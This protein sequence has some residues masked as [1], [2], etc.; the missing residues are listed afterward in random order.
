[1]QTARNQGRLK[2]LLFL[3][4]WPTYAYFYQ[5][6]S[7]NEAARLDQARALVE[8]GSLWVDTYAYNSADLI[9]YERDG[10]RHFYSGK[11]PGTTLLAAIPLKVWSTTL[12][13]LGLP[14]AV[15]WHWV[16]Y[17]TTISTVS[18]LSALAA[19]AVFEA[20]L[21]ITASVPFA[22]LGVIAVW[23]GSISFPFS[24]LMFG[25]QIAASLLALAFWL[26]VRLRWRGAAAFRHPRAALA[27][28]G[29]LAGL[30]VVTEYPTVILAALLSVYLLQTVWKEPVSARTKIKRLALFGVG[31]CLAAL[32]LVAYNVVI[33]GKV[34]YV[35]YQAY[36][37]GDG[38]SAF[39]AHAQGFL[40][41]HWPGWQSFV[42]VLA[43]ITIRP[44]RGLVYLGVEDGW[45]YALSPV[46]WLALPGL[47]VLCVRGDTRAEG[48][49]VAA[50][51]AAFL[52]FNA[53]Y[54]DSI[55]YWG[56]GASIGPRHLVPLLPLLAVPIAAAIRRFW[57]AFYPLLLVSVFYM[58]L[59]T[60]TE[61]RPGY[62]FRHPTRDLHFAN[63]M[64]GRLAL[65]QEHLF[66]TTGQLL[67]DDSVA[68]NLGKL[69]GLPGAWQL[70]P[71]MVW[72]LAIGILLARSAAEERADRGR[73][74]QR[75]DRLLPPH[76][77]GSR[78]LVP[79]LLVCFVL[80]VVTLPDLARALRTSAEAETGLLGRYYSNAIW[81]GK[82]R[83]VRVDE[84]ID[85]D[86]SE[87]PW[88]LPP[89]FSID[90]IGTLSV[91]RPGFYTFSLESDDGST[92]EVDGTLVIDNSGRHGVQERSGGIWLSGGPHRLRLRYFNE[93]FGG[94]VRLLWT[95]PES[96]RETVPT[97]VLRPSQA[98]G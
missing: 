91:E 77:R 20:V 9:S 10:E 47:V 30:A 11:A 98:S 33:F 64:S 84:R 53:S 75:L 40:G 81:E 65:N 23:L 54:G 55:I 41:I 72:W 39:P 58:L 66:D 92:L 4:L 28:A 21:L 27:I 22:L 78:I 90:W 5:S 8:D 60:A 12:R 57:W 70:A 95:P 45:I 93:L 13:I 74:R 83:E 80:L 71:L 6:G 73:E 51:S 31:A 29:F 63:Y 52:A 62:E 2:L 19:V 43:E 25:H 88:P 14:E 1:M 94:S 42:D 34:F 15:H 7:Q 82:P 36:L 67:T 56:G 68:F 38:P 97:T 96:D 46:L 59:A 48:L 26:I 89:P 3:L 35:P 87:P 50:A 24:T 49:L 16:V 69:V 86:W 61:P 18:L 17:L 37:E 44:Q 79:A 32:C 85:F 76:P